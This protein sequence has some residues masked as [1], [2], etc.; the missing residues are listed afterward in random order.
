[1]WKFDKV[2]AKANESDDRLKI[3]IG[4]IALGPGGEIVFEC[5]DQVDHQ[6]EDECQQDIDSDGI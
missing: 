3:I 5:C 6:V 1:L 4:V 2:Y